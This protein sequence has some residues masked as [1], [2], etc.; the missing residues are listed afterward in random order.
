MQFLNV[1]RDKLAEQAAQR[2]AAIA[3]MEAATD[4]AA[5]ESRSELN[6]TENAL[7]VEARDT[8]AKLDEEIAATEARIADFE[9]VAE[10]QSAAFSVP[11]VVRKADPIDV[12]ENRGATAGEIADALRRQMDA[13]VPDASSRDHVETLIKR[14]GGD[15]RWAS[16][17]LARSTPVYNSAFLKYMANPTMPAFTAEEARAIA[18]GTNTQGGLLSPT[19]LDPTVI[20]TNTGSA[21]VLRSI[22][23]V[24]TLTEGS[25]WY[26]VTSAG[27]TA[28]WD[29]ELA[30]VSDDSPEYA[31]VSIPVY[32]GSVFLAA[33]IEATQN[34]EGLAAD[35]AMLMADSKDRLEAAAFTTGSGSSQPTGIFTAL[36]ANTNV[37]IIST[38]A[39][40]IG[41]VDIHS[42]YRQVAQRWRANG[43]WLMHPLYSLAVKRLG[44]AVSS[45]YSGDLTRPAADMILGR[46]A[47][48]SDWAPSTQTTTANDNQ[49]VFGDFSNF[50]IVD[51]PGSFSVEY[52]PHVFSGTNGRP[53]GARGWYGWFRTGSDSVNDIGFRLLQ[54]K[55]SA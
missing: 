53:I 48:E 22:S 4:A 3:A 29:A 49:I 13:Q 42:V 44:T 35:I 9:K 19:H 5:A 17:L 28:S 18:V 34:I 25:T 6:E 41:E 38:T 1:L 54:D 40:V 15:D 46:P 16:N 8:V 37:E 2:D 20:V 52:I 27:S 51:K 39:A 26:G 10:R 14:H 50:V 7:Y 23:R 36:D 32:K 24:V 12:L 55:T 43:S 45:S 33:S 30:E 21:S 31:S 47:Y 11:Q